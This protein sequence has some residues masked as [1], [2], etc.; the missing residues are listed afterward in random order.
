MEVNKP[1]RCRFKFTISCTDGRMPE[2]LSLNKVLFL[3]LLVITLDI[4]LYLLLKQ[5]LF[6]ILLFYI[7]FRLILAYHSQGRVIYWKFQDFF[8]QASEYIGN[9]FL[10]KAS[11]YLWMLLLLSLLGLVIKIG[12]YKIIIY[13][14]I[15]L[16]VGFRK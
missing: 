16:S 6:I 4:F 7:I 11:D 12:L 13:L 8:L 14:V 10:N 5:G 3:L 1:H 15:L 9:V 2:E